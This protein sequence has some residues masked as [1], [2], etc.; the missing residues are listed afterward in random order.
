MSEKTPQPEQWWLCDDGEGPNFRI[1]AIGKNSKGQVLFED[2]QGNIEIVQEHGWHNWHHEPACTGWTWEPETFPQYVK[3]LSP[4][5]YAYIRIDSAKMSDAVFVRCDGTEE[6]FDCR[7]ESMWL[8]MRRRDRLTREQAEAL[9]QPPAEPI[10]AD[11]Y[12]SSA[13]MNFYHAE[14]NR[15]MG[16]H[17]W[18]QWKDRRKEFPGKSP[19][20]AESPDDWVTQDR[21]EARPC[22]ERRWVSVRTGCPGPWKGAGVLHLINTRKHGEV[23]NDY[24]LEL[25]C[26]R[27][28]LPPLPDEKPKTRKVVLKEFLRP[29]SDGSLWPYFSES[30]AALEVD[31]ISTSETRE[32]EVPL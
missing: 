9:V 17:F 31:D 10:P 5:F 21:E 3:T 23:C 28:D 16:N 25:R 4:E 32:V 27:D 24:R 7:N 2:S 19:A 29:S 6:E 15:G 1:Y 22:D 20:P 13:D 18:E 8:E 30:E 11:V 26:R 12:Y 14:T